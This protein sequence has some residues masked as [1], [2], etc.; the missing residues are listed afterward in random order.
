MPSAEFKL[1]ASKS[2]SE[3]NNLA[4]VVVFAIAVKSSSTYTPER[5]TFPV[6]STVMV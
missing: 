4:S 1:A 2:G 6:F 5:V 3:V